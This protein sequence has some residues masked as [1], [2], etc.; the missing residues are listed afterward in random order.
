MPA[1][2]L[3]LSLHGGPPDEANKTLLIPMSQAKDS[4]LQTI[5]TSFLAERSHQGA[6]YEFVLEEAEGELALDPC[7]FYLALA[8]YITAQKAT[9][10]V[11]SALQDA[12]GPCVT[13]ETS[14]R[15]QITAKIR[16]LKRESYQFC[17]RRD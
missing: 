9:E 11:R 10:D 16:L 14:G 8:P 15:A 13:F 4:F 6:H 7:G 5:A 12:F 3:C 1:A 2:K 17:K